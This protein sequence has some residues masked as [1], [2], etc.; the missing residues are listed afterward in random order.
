MARGGSGPA[1]TAVHEACAL[2]DYGEEPEESAQ[3]A[4]YLKAYRRFLKDYRPD[5]ELIEH[6][7]GTLGAWLRWDSGPVWNP[8]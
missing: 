5:W 7:M 1:R 2:I 4:G 6:P 3:I 8:L